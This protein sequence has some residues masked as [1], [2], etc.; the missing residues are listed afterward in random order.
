MPDKLAQHLPNVNATE[1]AELFGSIT[2]IAA[3][4]Y[5]DPTRQ[6]VIA[7]YGDTMRVMLIVAT[8][9]AVVPMLLSLGMPDWFLGDHQ[10]AVD[11]VDLKG[12]KVV[13]EAEASR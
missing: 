6:G 13:D 4:P 1:R 3:L 5:D 2:S 12:E 9:L 8:V 7:A 10:N 11:G